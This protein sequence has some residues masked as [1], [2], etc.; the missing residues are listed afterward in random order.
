MTSSDTGRESGEL[1]ASENY[2]AEVAAAASA[3]DYEEKTDVI[4]G[5]ENVTNRALQ[6]LSTVTK[7]LDLCG[8]R[9]GPSIIVANE[10]VMQSILTYIIWELDKGSSQRL[11]RKISCIAK[12]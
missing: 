7:T 1:L 9:Y 3:S 2:D 10:Q 12:S 6:I 11:L 4:Y 5:E 8:D